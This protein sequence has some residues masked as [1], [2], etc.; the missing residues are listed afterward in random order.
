MYT[1]HTFRSTPYAA[2]A[3]LVVAAALAAGPGAR[4]AVAQRAAP[5]SATT[6]A[7][8]ARAVILAVAETDPALAERLEAIHA[9]TEKYRDV[10]AALEDGY[11]RDPLDMCVTPE[12]EGQPRQLGDMGIHYFRPDL[13]GLTGTEPRV[14]GVGTHTDFRRPAILVYEPQPDG[15]LVLVAV[16]NLVF[17]EAWAESGREAPPEF[18]GNQYYTTVDNPDTEPDEAHG[19]APHYELHLWLYRENPGGLFAQFNPNVTCRHHT[20]ARHP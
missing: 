7:D 9:A 3:A 15:R 4:H 11:V 8:P 14:S 18:S 2:L 19:F 6:D 5:A 17:R 12:M 13:L 1:F 10:E 16:E 20:G